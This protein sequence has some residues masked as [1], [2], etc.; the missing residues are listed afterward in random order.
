M[1]AWLYLELWQ[2]V[3]IFPENIYREF[4]PGKTNRIGFQQ[5]SGDY[6]PGKIWLSFSIKNVYIDVCVMILPGNLT[7][8]NI[9]G[10]S[11]QIP[12]F[13]TGNL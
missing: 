13:L 5:I 4:V 6:V 3:Y 9:C 12:G 8:E 1:F 11:Q 10:H 2:P 7:R